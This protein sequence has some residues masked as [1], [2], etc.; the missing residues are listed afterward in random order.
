MCQALHP[1]T[2]VCFGS[3]GLRTP[4]SGVPVWPVLLRPNTRSKHWPL[5]PM[6]SHATANVLRHPESAHIRL[7]CLWLISACHPSHGRLECDPR[8]PQPPLA[9]CFHLWRWGNCSLE[10]MHCSHYRHSLL[11]QLSNPT[12]RS[13]ALCSPGAQPCAE[14]IVYALGLPHNPRVHARERGVPSPVLRQCDFCF[15]FFAF[16]GISGLH[17][18]SAIHIANRKNDGARRGHHPAL[19]SAA[20]PRCYIATQLRL[21]ASMM[22]LTVDARCTKRSNP[23][24]PLLPA[25]AQLPLL[26]T[27]ALSFRQRPRPATHR[28]THAA[29]GQKGPSPLG[30]VPGSGLATCAR[31]PR[32]HQSMRGAC[33]LGQVS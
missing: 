33:Q 20:H 22:G 26:A 14:L 27:A 10:S 28:H 8:P 23:P 2:G 18:T 30:D 31:V 7:A 24:L 11:A 15:D 32:L 4:L 19:G 29:V 3:D 1:R 12:K 25:A 6:R 5:L 21:C 17:G 16:M 13:S 9:C